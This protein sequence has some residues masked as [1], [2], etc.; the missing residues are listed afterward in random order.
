M[1]EPITLTQYLTN[2][3]RDL[4]RRSH[5]I[6]PF[7]IAC[8][9]QNAR[10]AGSAVVC[11]QRLAVICALPKERLKEVLDALKDCIN[12][13]RATVHYCRKGLV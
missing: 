5:F 10:F 8:A 2:G 6:S 4:I 7:L 1:S 3:E 11:L 9:T 12:L 13:G